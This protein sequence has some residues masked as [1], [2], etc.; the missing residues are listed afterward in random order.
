[1]RSL[2][3]LST[4]RDRHETGTSILNKAIKQLERCLILELENNESKEMSYKKPP[5]FLQTRNKDV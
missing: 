3:K 5:V 2:P 4:G 1:M